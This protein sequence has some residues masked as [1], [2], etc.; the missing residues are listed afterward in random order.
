MS[1]EFESAGHFF[2]FEDKP[3]GCL[4]HRLL[5][6]GAVSGQQVLVVLRDEVSVYIPSFKL[7]VAG[8]PEQEVHI[9]TQANNLGREANQVPAEHRKQHIQ[10]GDTHCHWIYLDFHFKTVV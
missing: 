5:G 8:E 6:Y 10:E 9:G 7:G 4:A 1:V 2:L 3:Q